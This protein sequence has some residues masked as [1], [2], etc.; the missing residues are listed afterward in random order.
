MSDDPTIEEMV[1]E[2]QGKPS[3]RHVPAED[4]T[5]A[6]HFEAIRRTGENVGDVV[7]DPTTKKESE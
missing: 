1:R 6:D 5:A 3:T 7:V 2:K 4:A